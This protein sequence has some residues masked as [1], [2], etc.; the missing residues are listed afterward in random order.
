MMIGKGA[1]EK[2]DMKIPS[3][4]FTKKILGAFAYIDLAI[5]TFKV[6]KLNSNPV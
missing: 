2:V 3:L 4:I 1:R 6:E 5:N